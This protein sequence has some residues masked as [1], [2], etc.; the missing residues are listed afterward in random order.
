MKRLF[1]ILFIS[2]FVSNYALAQFDEASNFLKGGVNDAQLLL[3]E[4]LRPYGNILSTNLSGGWYNTASIHDFPGFDITFSTSMSFAPSMHK[5]FDATKLGLTKLTLK[6]GSPTVLP[7]AV[8]ESDG[9][10]AT[11]QHLKNGYSLAE[12]DMPKGSG[13]GFAPMFMLQAGV[14][15]PFKTEI[16]GRFCPK[17]E[18]F[19]VKM[20]LW[21]VGLKHSLKQYIPVMKMVPLWNLSLQAGFTRFYS[22]APLEFLPD[23]YDSPETT[24]VTGNLALYDSQEIQFNMNSLTGNLL[25]S[26]NL[27]VLCVYAGVGFV[28][29]STE[30]KLLGNYPMVTDFNIAANKPIIGEYVTDPINIEIKNANG[31]V[32]PRFNLGTRF[33]FAVITLHFDYTYAD[34][35]MATAG[36]GFSFR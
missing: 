19:D 15:L 17:V 32:L 23:D 26:I 25:A 10:T 14:G 3:T 9:Q 36:L 22:S 18:I 12:F 30:L 11:F 8:G 13:F 16:T 35:S 29:T 31:S 27:P 20:G 2:L 33:K 5:E 6:S 28:S 7:T 24:D 4:Y 1:Y 21:G 34:Y